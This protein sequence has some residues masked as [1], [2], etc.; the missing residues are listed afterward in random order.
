MRLFTSTFAILKKLSKG[1]LVIMVLNF[2]VVTYLL[3]LNS[4]KKNQY[5]KSSS[6]I[7]ANKFR[8]ALK[9]NKQK[10]SALSF[11]KTSSNGTT[12]A[13]QH[14]RLKHPQSRYT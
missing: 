10:I 5:E 4:C 8:S 6:G 7:A 13:R 14:L 12:P 1:M 9:E 2:A 3:M 11:G